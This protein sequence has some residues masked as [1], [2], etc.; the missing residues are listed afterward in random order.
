MKNVTVVGSFPFKYDLRVV[1]E[2][3][4]EMVRVG[5]NYPAYPQLRS[6][7]EMFLDP[8]V[9]RGALRKKGGKY[10]LVDS[11]LMGK[12]SVKDYPEVELTLRLA[13]KVRGGIS[14]LRAPIT[15]PFTLSSNIYLSEEGENIF[16]SCLSRIDLVYELAGYVGEL[17]KLFNRL[18]YG[19]I[20]IDE[21]ILSVI[22]GARR[23]LFNYREDEVLEAYERSLPIKGFKGTH[24]CGAL[25]PKLVEILLEAELNL[26][27][28]EFAGS[29]M[30]FDRFSLRELDRHDKFLAVGVVSSRSSRIEEVSE[31]ANLIKKALE[32]YD[33]R[34]FA[35]K[36]DC[37]FG[38]L[39][40]LA[41]GELKRVVFAKLS[42]IRKALEELKD[43]S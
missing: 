38:G 11:S 9:N 18:G 43:K 4:M 40:G 1:E 41:E 39:T 17:S 28:H 21:P 19:L 34:V 7:I 32:R 27:D 33:W 37:G 6:F 30:N 22:I 14:G 25:S 13:S 15:G 20:V 29:P 23:S 2:T 5:V 31:V 35:F 24:V 36:P 16:K 8:L 42:R 12:P 3:F 26:L 10:Y